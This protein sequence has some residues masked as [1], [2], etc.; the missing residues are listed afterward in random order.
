MLLTPAFVLVAFAAFQA[1]L[2]THARTEARAAARDAAVLVARFDADPIDVRRSV[3]DS[4]SAERSLRVVDTPG[5][6]P[7]EIVDDPTGLVTVTVRVVAPGILRWTS[8]SVTVTEAVP[9]EG[10]R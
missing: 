5:V 4:L 10:F 2:W 8:T 3:I 6:D 9:N 7:V 1:A